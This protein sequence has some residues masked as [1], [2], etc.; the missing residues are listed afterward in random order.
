MPIW[1]VQDAAERFGE[2]LD[3]CLNN[4]PQVISRHGIEVAVLVPIE[5]WQRVQ[6][7]ARPTLKELLLADS[8]RWENPLPSRGG[9]QTRSQSDLN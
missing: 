2:L 5:Q 9:R 6:H 3:T 4:G 1:T 8:P 7:A